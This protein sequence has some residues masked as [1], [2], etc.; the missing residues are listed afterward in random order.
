[1][2][3]ILC[4]IGGL[5]VLAPSFFLC[6]VRSY[7]R[8]QDTVG[9]FVL[10]GRN[11]Y[12]VWDVCLINVIGLGLPGLGSQPAADRDGRE[13]GGAI[14]W[15]HIFVGIGQNFLTQLLSSWRFLEEATVILGGNSEVISCCWLAGFYCIH[16]TILSRG[17]KCQMRMGDALLP[18]G[19]WRPCWSLPL[20]VKYKQ[21]YGPSACSNYSCFSWQL[22]HKLETIWACFFCMAI[23]SLYFQSRESIYFLLHVPQIR[24]SRESAVSIGV[25]ETLLSFLKLNTFLSL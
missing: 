12:L 21:D 23:L 6:R 8:K 14:S 9:F 10:K 5:G 17:G 3:S 11:Y 15:C 18:P 13:H 20:N 19:G 1:M 4:I 24:F 2:F 25:V 7:Q 16:T 22:I